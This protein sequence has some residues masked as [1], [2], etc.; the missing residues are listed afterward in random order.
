MIPKTERIYIKEWLKVKPYTKQVHS[1]SFYLAISNRVKD[2]IVNSSSY[3]LINH[4]LSKEEI[5]ILSCFITSYFED[6]ISETNL[7]TSFV[8]RHK[9]LYNRELPFFNPIEYF[10]QEINVAD[11]AFL[12]WYF[13]NAIQ[14][15]KF[16]HF[17]NNLISDYA[18]K[19]W[20]IF[21]E[22]WDNAP[23]NVM[24]KTFYTLPEVE[25]DYYKARQLMDNILFNSY[26]FLPDTNRRL[27]TSED[28]IIENNHDHP[29]LLG[30]LN[31]NRDSKVYKLRTSLL[32]LS[33]KEWAAYVLGANHPQ[34][35]N[36]L[37]MSSRIRGFFFYKG[38]DEKNIF[39]QHIATGK[40][41]ILTKKSFDNSAELVE[42]DTI[43]FLG[44]VNWCNE[45]WFSG[46]YF[47]SDNNEK[48]VEY[49]KNDIS[50]YHDL[51]ILDHNDARVLEALQNQFE[52]FLNYSRGKQI[53]FLKSDEIFDF[54]EKF[55]QHYNDLLRLNASEDIQ[56]Q[57]QD[58]SKEYFT[59][60]SKK[61]DLKKIAESGLVFFNPKSGLETAVGFNNVFPLHENPFYVET[62]SVEK[63]FDLLMSDEI[64][65]ELALYC[66]EVNKSHE[67]FQKSIIGMYYMND[68]DFLLRFLKKENYHTYPA[69]T[70]TSNRGS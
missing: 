29:N 14:E 19:I 9:S 39:I 68:I 60:D 62:G 54:M 52:V 49:Q 51:S 24:L 7:W 25:V 22:E 65:K 18:L 20:L 44:L 43:V 69:I 3:G 35:Q 13:M 53:V 57:I 64:S 1:D 28:E 5:N 33:G 48:F 66:I 46:I 8:E 15:E 23:V 45:W 42:I 37:S 34:Y 30:I 6:I 12:I 63:I 17:M 56:P 4:Y 67:Y 16:I 50:N 41:F 55:A 70:L 11:I 58:K 10:E 47:K 27:I 36:F 32:S 59:E 61:I 40:D 26:L 31:D 2:V 21:D 38:Q